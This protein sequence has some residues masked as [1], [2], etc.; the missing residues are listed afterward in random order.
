VE[1][2]RG[3]AEILRRE[4]MRRITVSAN[5]AQG[6]LSEKVRQ[7]SAVTDKMG[8]PPGYKIKFAGTYEFQ[9]E[10]FSAL[11][12]ALI[13]AIILTYVVLAMII[14]SFIHPITIM[15]TLPLGLIGSALGIFFGGQTINIVS[16]MSMIMLV[17]IVVNNAILLLDYVGRLRKRGMT[18]KEAV[19]CGCPTRL[20]AI[21]MTNL[22]IVIGMIP[23]VIGRSEGYEMRAAM[24][25]VTIGGILISTFFTLVLIP[26]LYFFFESWWERRF[27]R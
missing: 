15:I 8:L 23:Q 20:R 3:E 19:L 11:F 16:L 14:E 2:H 6:T 9:Q 22:A 25:Y 21:I 12:E 24:G 17:G 26:T 10:S 4:R 13:L 1:K 5:I 27:A 7:V 18:L